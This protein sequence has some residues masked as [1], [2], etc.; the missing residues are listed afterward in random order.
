MYY[1]RFQFSDEFAK[2]GTIAQYDLPIK[3]VILNNGWQGMVRQ[4]Q[5]AFYNERYS[6]SNMSSGM[7]D[8]V[9]IANAYGLKG[10]TLENSSDFYSQFKLLLESNGLC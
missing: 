4:W 10:F 2:L 8:F 1:R 3:I 5:Q 6:H 9:E 7:P